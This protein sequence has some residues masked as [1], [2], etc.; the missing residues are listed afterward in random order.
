MTV[1]SVDIT[2]GPYI[3]NGVAQVFDYSFVIQDESEVL[4]YETD[5]AG[6]QTLLTVNTD[7]VVIN[8]GFDDG[9]ISRVAGP[10]PTGWQ[11]YIRSNYPAT[12]LTSFN[13]QGGFFPDL[14]ENAM[15]KLTYLIQQVN[16]QLSRTLRYPDSYPEGINGAILPEPEAEKILR[17]RADLLG[18][19]NIDI[20]LIDPGAVVLSDYTK[21]VDSWAAIANFEGVDGEI[22][23]LKGH[24]PI[25]GAVNPYRGGGRFIIRTGSVTNDNGTKRNILTPDRYAQRLDVEVTTPYMFGAYGDGVNNDCD[26][27]RYNIA[28]SKNIYLPGNSTFLIAPTAASGDFMLYLGTA[29]G[30]ANRSGM[31]IFGDGRSS[32]IK[33]ANNVGASKLLFGLA[34]GDVLT[35]CT[36]RDFAF[37][38]N[39]ANN[40]QANFGD[41]LRYNSAFYMSGKCSNFLFENL[42]IKN[43]SGH[44]AIRVGA[45]DVN[46]YADN[47]RI[48][49]CDFENFGIAIPGNNQQDVSV[50]YLQSS[51]IHIE[52]CTFKNPNF[53]FSL[54]RGQTALELHGDDSTIVKNN[55]F[56]YVQLPA[57]FVSSYKNNRNVL[58]DGNVFIE[59]NY[60]FSADSAELT[61]ENITVVNNLYTSSKVM[62]VVC[63]LGGSAETAKTRQ[64]IVFKNN[65]LTSTGTDQ[66]TPIFAFEDNWIRSVEISSN[67]ISNFYGSL[68][69][70]AGT[71]QNS[72]TLTIA[73][74]NNVLDSLGSNAGVSPNDPC[75][76]FVSTTT[77]GINTLT[78]ENNTL[79]NSMGKDYSAVGCYRLNGRILNTNV[80]GTTGNVSKTYPVATGVIT[81]AVT[82]V[83]ESNLEELPVKHRSS[84]IALAGTSSV[85]LYDFAAFGNNDNAFLEVKIY[86]NV[87]GLA[88]G[89]VQSYDVM[90]SSNGKVVL[91]QTGA[92]TYD[93]DV[94]LELSGSILR[95]RSTTA[96][97]LSFNYVV[98]GDSNKNIVWL[99]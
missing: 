17:W 35:D 59:C 67:T 73:I 81:G 25:I 72:D 16:D 91:K 71:V 51:R 65:I 30:Q 28:A 97:A 44:Q 18:L 39:A 43:I 9:S 84:T 34:S 64:H 54:N 77:G 85:N 19:E 83:I 96:T 94:I 92:G 50:C 88:F 89:T 86:A 55:I 75:F 82:K 11:W 27:F 8:V 12:Q 37:D 53:T 4:V 14:H 2:D 47:I 87:G 95:V 40:L 48:I 23:Y 58:L 36:F 56:T 52:G 57:L 93:A 70:V 45:D 68:L 29:N 15:D 24:T 69:Y 90:Y 38:L 62:S 61:Q 74:K 22:F 10:L 80:S 31:T 98:T 63:P 33:L 79:Y 7:Y 3:G 76:V 13:S 5:L 20:S 49:N 66:D 60:L 42:Y 1:N 99:V 21:K 32:V 6:N 78:I 46:K 41:P 26:P